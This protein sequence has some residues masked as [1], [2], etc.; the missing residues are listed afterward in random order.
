MAP[1]EFEKHIREKLNEQQIKPSERTWERIASRLD[2]EGIKRRRKN[3]WRPWMYGA[4]ACLLIASGF[5]LTRE[6]EQMGADMPGIAG[7][8]AREPEIP[9][10]RNIP[11]GVPEP[12]AGELAGTPQQE[13]RPEP[14]VRDTKERQPI[15]DSRSRDSLPESPSGTLASSDSMGLDEQI[16]RQLD[17]VL[18]E[19]ASLEER[20]GGISETTV[21]S[22]LRR[23]QERIAANRYRMPRDSVDAMSLLS[24]AEEELDQTFREELFDRL[25]S[26]F[27]RIR[28]AVADR[29]N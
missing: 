8:P 1:I 23:A 29:N 22:L 13:E 24:A 20:D 21:D 27:L 14:G 12:S 25:K 4:A 10:L 17:A 3:A 26:G 5:W 15:V 18:Q 6:P 7:P 9:E 28:T 11:M 2:A 16:D 19:V